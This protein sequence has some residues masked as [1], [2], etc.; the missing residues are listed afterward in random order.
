MLNVQRSH[1][2]IALTKKIIVVLLIGIPFSAALSAEE[3]SKPW[4]IYA[5]GFGGRI[6]G[7]KF[8]NSYWLTSGDLMQGYE[9]DNNTLS[10][11][12]V[13]GNFSGFSLGYAYDFMAESIGDMGL[14]L[15]GELSVGLKSSI[16]NG[17]E[18]EYQ[19]L[20]YDPVTQTM[21]LQITQRA[22]TARKVGLYGLTGGLIY[23]PYRKFP[24]GLDFGLGLWLFSQKYVSETCRANEGIANLNH[25]DD[26][27]EGSYSGQ[28]N[29]N[30]NHVAFMIKLGLNYRFLDHF[31][32]DLSYRPFWLVSGKSTGSRYVGSE[33]AIYAPLFINL[34][35]L[36][37]A[38]ISIYF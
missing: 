22:Q 13:S 30:I 20:A 33:D 12:K 15:Y 18:L 27:G 5:S 26:A 19:Y 38:C 21:P 37:S 14:E 32:V 4:R 7:V 34:G 10:H 3:E 8:Y 31:I 2:F 28:G 17:R 24:V 23:I 25:V 36:L 6:S 11:E 16:P 1:L 29:W 35:G 9:N